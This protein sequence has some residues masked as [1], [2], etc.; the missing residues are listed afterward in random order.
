MNNWA[1]I[2][3]HKWHS[4]KYWLVEKYGSWNNGLWNKYLYKWVVFHP[5]YNPTNQGGMITAQWFLKPILS[6]SHLSHEKNPLTFHYTGCLWLFNR[7]PYNGLLKSPYNRIVFHPL[8]TLNNQGPFFHCS[9]ELQPHA[10][11][12]DFV[13]LGRS[14][15][16]WFQKY[17]SWPV[18]LPPPSRTPPWK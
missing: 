6:E 1:V 5:L 15:L 18:N 13:S 16:E 9:P 4:I 17:Q 8:Y 14:S 7:D 12:S 10:Y 3:T 11:D 2:K